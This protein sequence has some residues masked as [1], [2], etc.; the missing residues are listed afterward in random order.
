[1][2]RNCSLLYLYSVILVLLTD[3]LSTRTS[4]GMVGPSAAVYMGVQNGN[5]AFPSQSLIY[6]D[7]TNDADERQSQCFSYI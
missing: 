3:E 7:L 5:P 2:D 1:M 4:E 6:T